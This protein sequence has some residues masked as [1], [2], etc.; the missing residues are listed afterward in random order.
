MRHWATA[1][2]TSPAMRRAGVGA[3][4]KYSATLNA[5]STDAVASS[6]SIAVL[7]NYDVFGECMTGDE[8]SA[9]GCAR[10]FGKLAAK[11]VWQTP[12]IAFFQTIP[13]MFSRRP[14][15]HA[16]YASDSLLE[17][18]RRNVESS[19]L[20]AEALDKYRLAGKI[21]LW[22]IHDLQLAGNRFLAGCDGLVPG[23]CLHDELEWFTKPGFSPLEALQTP[24]LIRLASWGAKTRRV[25]LRSGS[26]PIWCYWSRSFGGHPQY[27]AD[28]RRDP[29]GQA[30]NDAFYS[31][32]H[33]E[34][35]ARGG[36][37]TIE[38]QARL[39]RASIHSRPR[40]E[41]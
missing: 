32:R 26:G 21:S 24:R 6:A 39:C 1:L 9:A 25:P 3:S 31:H 20:P 4:A 35:P 15:A 18:T 36:S 16:E 38:F 8:Y 22:A 10:L 12:T 14:L 23:F 7:S 30:R 11:G 41:G 27:F 17:L 40:R 29:T 28:L 13:D 37:V 33:G 5:R 19:H 2:R 34:A